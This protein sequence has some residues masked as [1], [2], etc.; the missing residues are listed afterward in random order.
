MKRAAMD[1]ILPKTGVEI[2]IGTP[3][4][5][6]FCVYIENSC[7]E[8]WDYIF[9]KAIDQKE[10]QKGF[11]ADMQLHVGPSSRRLIYRLDLCSVLMFCA[12]QYV[13]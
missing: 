1:A 4:S 11:D 13:Y 7:I 9:N 8:H 5:I 2:R 10:I 3:P 6:F 12:E